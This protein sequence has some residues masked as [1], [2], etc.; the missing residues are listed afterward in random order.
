MVLLQLQSW[1]CETMR[2]SVAFLQAAFGRGSPI[3][4]AEG[5][6]VAL[7]KRTNI[8]WYLDTL[9]ISIVIEVLCETVKLSV[10]FFDRHW[11]MA[12]L[13]SCPGYG[14]DTAEMGINTEVTGLVCWMIKR[15]IE[16][17][18]IM[19]DNWMICFFFLDSSMIL[20]YLFFIPKRWRDVT[21][22]KDARTGV[23]RWG[24]LPMFHQ[25][26]LWSSLWCRSLS[27]VSPMVRPSWCNCVVT[28]YASRS[29]AWAGWWV[30]LVG[31]WIL[32]G[33]EDVNIIQHML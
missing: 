2:R 3:L 24:F 4:E 29:W 26:M 15:W 5:I 10:F 14:A 8:P 6:P 18:D 11:L 33:F 21:S 31:W 12:I 23:S 7:I 20:G 22:S 16:I 32:V 9:C 30:S 1:H 27:G 19:D 28:F 13:V 25:L 17:M